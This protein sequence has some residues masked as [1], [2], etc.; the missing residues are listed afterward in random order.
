MHSDSTGGGGV[1]GGGDTQWMT[2]GGGILH[3]EAPPE[4]LVMSGGLFHGLQ[5][6]VNLPREQK[7]MN[8]KYQDIGGGQVKLLTTPD[9]GS[10]LRLIAGGLDGHSGPGVTQTPITLIH[11]TISPGAEITLPWRPDFNALVYALAGRGTAG[12]EG[13]P[14]ETGQAVAF[15]RGDSVTL[16]AAETQE[17]R[18]PDLEVVL[19]GGRPIREPMVQYGPFVMNSQVELAQAFEDFKAGRLGQIPAEHV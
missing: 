5:L 17:S 12:A 19:L 4:E 8:P 10:L 1:L 14:F 7:M 3:I 9:G 18:S 2:A 11:A 16:R 15:G 13:R 6:W